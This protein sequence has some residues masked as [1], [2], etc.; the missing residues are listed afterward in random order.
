MPRLPSVQLPRV[1]PGERAIIVDLTLLA[2]WNSRTGVVA[3]SSLFNQDTDIS[4]KAAVPHSKTVL[5]ALVVV[6]L[7]VALA[8]ADDNLEQRAI[9]N[10]GAFWSIWGLAK[11]HYIAAPEIKGG[12][13]QRV[14]ITPKPRNPWD[15]G[16]YGAITR[17]VKRGDVVVLKFYARTVAAP[18]NSDLVMVTG[19]V[20]EAGEGTRSVTG[21]TNFLFGKQWK[22]YCAVGTASRDYPPGSLSAGLKL[23]TGEQTID[24]SPLEILDMGPTSTSGTC[25]TAERL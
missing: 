10:P 16:T 3:P 25:H 24:F 1:Q 23:G 14:A 18:E 19:S 12:V 13:A 11:A 9:G 6:V 15:A 4:A 22:L 7:S 8:R 2:V 20:Y 21:D 5:G 17:A